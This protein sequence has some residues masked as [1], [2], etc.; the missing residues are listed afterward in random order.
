MLSN[1][2][3]S[4]AILANIN[5][6]NSHRG[7]ISLYHALTIASKT[8]T[9]LSYTRVVGLVACAAFLAFIRL[10]YSLANRA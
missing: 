5:Q 3:V 4:L 8:Y 7:S 9:L 10:V 2:S 1:T 6:A